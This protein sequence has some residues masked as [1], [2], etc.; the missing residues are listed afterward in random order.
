MLNINK[1]FSLF[2]EKQESRSIQLTKGKVAAATKIEN[3]KIRGLE[4]SLY[5]Q[6][7]QETRKGQSLE[8][9][10]QTGEFL[11]IGS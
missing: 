11:D 3:F 1:K 4:L 9:Q 5:Y 7:T 8:F 10:G 2:I 6:P